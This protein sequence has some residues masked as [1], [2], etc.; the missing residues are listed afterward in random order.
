MSGPKRRLWHQVFLLQR[1]GLK[2]TM[3]VCGCMWTMANVAA[4]EEM[5]VVKR[6]FVRSR[7]TAVPVRGG[8]P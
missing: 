5:V 6:R 8:P 2:L 7:E 4:I 3:K 1:Y